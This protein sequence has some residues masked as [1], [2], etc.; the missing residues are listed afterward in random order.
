M[1][2]KDK[3]YKRLKD[4]GYN[5]KYREAHREEIRNKY[6]EASK[7]YH[8]DRLAR[9]RLY[10][11]TYLQEHPCIDCGESDVCVLEF[12]HVR[13]TKISDVSKM[14]WGSKP[15]EMIQDEIDKCDVRCANC[16]RRIT[17]QRAHTCYLQPPIITAL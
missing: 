11:R 1:P 16:H 13:G 17:Q 12:D 6:K 4:K 2:Y 15:I 7:I 8:K 9:N 14:V 5:R 3:A 10:V